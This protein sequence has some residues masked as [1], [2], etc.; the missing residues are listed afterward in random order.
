MYALPLYIDPVVLFY[1]RDILSTAGYPKPAGNWVEMIAQVPEITLRDNAGNITRSGLAMG[2]SNNVHEMKAVYSALALQAD[3]EFTTETSSGELRSLFGE[4]YGRTL[5]PA[6]SALRFYVQFGN[7]DNELYSWNSAFA[8]SDE[9]FAAG[10]VAYLV[11]FASTVEDIEN[12][13]PQIDFAIGEL[14]VPSSTARITYGRVYGGYITRTTEN[15]NAALSVLYGLLA[16][17][18][19]LS[20]AQRLG[21]APSRQDALTVVVN[22]PVREV[23]RRSATFSQTWLDPAPSGTELIISDMI[24]SVIAGQVEPPQ[25]VETA[26]NRFSQIVVQ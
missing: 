3:E 4:N 21:L 6:E 12:R 16:P 25:A 10:Q 5:P 9:A 11:D 23:I 24:R 8:R 20:L 13:N 15:Y 18:V 26:R 22:D 17:D 19:N 7:V 1:N 2:T 14:P